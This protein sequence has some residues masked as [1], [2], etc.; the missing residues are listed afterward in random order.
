WLVSRWHVRMPRIGAPS[1]SSDNGLRRVIMSASTTVVRG[2]QITGGEVTRVTR[3]DSLV[4]QAIGPSVTIQVVSRDTLVSGG[5]ATLRLEGTDY[6]ATGDAS[7]RIRLSPVL[8]GRYRARVSTP[9]MDSLGMPPVIRDVETRDGT[10]VDSLNLPS[11]RDVLLA[12]C[13]RDSVGNGEGM[14][15]G[16]VR[17]QRDRPLRSAAVT[18]TWQ[19]NFSAIGTRD[20]GQLSYSEKTLGALTQDDGHWRVCG[21]PRETALAVRVV[22]DSGSD[23]QRVR[24]AADRE[25]AA[26]DLVVHLVVP[27]L[28]REARTAIGE[29]PPARALVEIAVVALGGSPLPDATVEIVGEGQ[30]RT[31]VTGPRG[32]ALVPDVAPG[33]LVVRA[34]HVGFKPG[35][36]AV[37]VEAGRNTVPI[38]LSVVSSPTLD[39]VRV[40]GD[41]R[42]S[43]LRRLDEF[44][45]RRINHTATVTF[46]R[47]DIIRRNPVDAWQMLTA[48]ASVRIVDS[49]GVTAESTRSNNVNPDLSVSKCYMTIM[50]DGMIMNRNPRQQAFDLRLL[51]KPEEIHG[52]EVFAGPASIPV[53]YA[54]SGDD[55]WCGMIAIW[56]R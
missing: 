39:T 4:H 38:I 20:G 31:V 26:V 35:Q 15:H 14:L 9:L 6:A 43:G 21:V 29:R 8:A 24:L 33:L 10:H 46:T 41:Q 55:K 27:T 3:H 44:E 32:R 17:D 34:K 16:D 7:G 45:T 53:Q 49:A 2:I 18:V 52:I 11:P 22:T 30:T 50:V 5:S 13:P 1:R 19:G 54:G 51:P 25:F 47:D 36:L 37:T 40:V 23:L 56:T 12:A 28:N 48:V 42:L